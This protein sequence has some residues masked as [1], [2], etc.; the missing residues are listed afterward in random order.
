MTS[1]DRRSQSEHY[2]HFLAAEYLWMTGLSYADNVR[3]ARAT[4]REFGITNPRSVVDL[5]CGPGFHL[6]AA[7]DL[8]AEHA[9]GFDT[10]DELI[11]QARTVI[12]N[13]KVTFFRR[14][15]EAFGD[16]L[17]GSHDLFLCLGDTLTHLSDLSAIE[18]LISEIASRLT[19]NGKALISFRDY[20]DPDVVYDTKFVVQKDDRKSLT[21]RLSDHGETVLVTDTLVIEGPEGQTILESSYTKCKPSF[22]W[23]EGALGR[24]GLRIGRRATSGSMRKIVV[25]H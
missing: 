17:D 24:H 7:L 18:S 19:K 3:L 16:V 15:L 9:I 12:Q 25:T 21:C 1:P 5:G 20:N 4:F 23:L 6:A 8:G 11:Q 14:P 13:D 2:R 10:S 22:F